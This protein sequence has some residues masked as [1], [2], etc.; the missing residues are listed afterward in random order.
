M[1]SYQTS[2]RAPSRDASSS[3][4]PPERRRFWVELPGWVTA[5][6]QERMKKPNK[7][8]AEVYDL[9]CSLWKV[10]SSFGAAEEDRVV[11][12]IT[13]ALTKKQDSSRVGGLAAVQRQALAQ[14]VVQVIEFLIENSS[15]KPN[16]LGWLGPPCRKVTKH[17]P[18]RLDHFPAPDLLHWLSDEVPKDTEKSL[19]HISDQPLRHV[20]VFG[21][22]L[23]INQYSNHDSRKFSAA[24]MRLSQIW[25]HGFFVTFTSKAAASNPAGLQ[26]LL[27]QLVMRQYDALEN[28]NG[29]H[30]LQLWLNLH[31]YRLLSPSSSDEARVWSNTR[32]M[33]SLRA[34]NQIHDPDLPP[35]PVF[36]TDRMENG[37]QAMFNEQGIS[38]YLQTSAI[39]DRL[40]I[41]RTE[42]PSYIEALRGI[43]DWNHHN[44]DELG[45]IQEISCRLV[46]TFWMFRL[47]FIVVSEEERSQLN[48][49]LRASTLGQSPLPTSSFLFH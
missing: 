20:A 21:K 5:Y 44:G 12:V 16:R 41:P 34:F 7:T 24:S 47:A 11:Y 39:L 49:R 14:E 4:L 27:S 23:S 40:K 19:R 33:A 15:A 46:K 1:S 45:S 36:N 31:T 8:N 35:I 2:A 6:V 37:I 32:R 13:E 18:H 17:R 38:P 42:L 43:Y 30:D 25:H 10:P 29:H 3:G 48:P 22:F 28:P 26:G 9:L